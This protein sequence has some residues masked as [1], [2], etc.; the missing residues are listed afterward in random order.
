MASSSALASRPAV[1]T[2]VNPSGQRRRIVLGQGVFHAGR[3]PDN[4]LVLRDN[5]VSRVH[6]RITNEGTEYILEDLNSRHGLFVNNEKLT[7]PYHLQDRDSIT[8]GLPDG[9]QIVFHREEDGVAQLADLVLERSKAGNAGG[10]LPKLRALVEVA[11]A[12]QGSFSIDQVLESVVDAALTVTGCERGFLLLNE[13]GGLEVKVA[14]DADGSVLS[15]NDLR[16]PRTLIQRALDQRRELLSMHFDPSRDEAT[17]PDLSVERLELRSVVC[18]PIVR[19][20]TAQGDETMVAI[21]NETAG[22]LYLDSRIDMADLTAGNRE[23]LQTLALEASTILENARLLEDE[24]MRQRLEEELRI[25][26]DI[27]R[28]LLPRELPLTGWFQVAASSVPSFHVGG[29]YYDVEPL[30]DGGYA[31]VV[32]DVSGKGVSSALLASL[33]QGAFLL[34]T[35]DKAQI[36]A[37]L[38]R[39]NM[40]LYERTGGEKYATLFFAAIL[41]DGTM[42]WANAGHCKPFLVRASGAVETLPPTSMPVGMLPIAQFEAETTTL[43]PGD[44][45]VV[46]SDGVSEAQNFAG[47]YFET[48]RMLEMMLAGA[49]LSSIDLHAA[50]KRTINQFT[51]GSPQR[52]DMTL[53][54]AQ[55]RPSEV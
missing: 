27:Q 54:I 53:L 48:S 29:D 13:A 55:F 45:L 43:G 7:G 37:M 20:R 47:E 30:V 6:L 46:Y 1:L 41:P 31:V 40:Y 12:L 35:S 42:H 22:V 8:F 14:R 25:A 23:L 21:R 5:R 28:G 9:Y 26:R 2:V 11:R 4:Q 15:S 52:D 24:R 44:R 18:V 49:N 3:Q 17:S 39:I 32:A 34:A 16:V 50:L 33:L 38:S 36:G 10:N 19:V 51:G